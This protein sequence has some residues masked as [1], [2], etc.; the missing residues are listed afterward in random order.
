MTTMNVLLKTNES[1]FHHQIVEFA[2]MYGLS[3]WDWV[4]LIITSFSLIIAIISVIIATKTLI[5]QKA[6][7]KNTQP[8]MNIEIQQ[9]L[10]GQKLLCILDSYIYLFALQYFLSKFN[11]KV[12][13]SSH[14]WEL[15]KL[16]LE[17]MDESLFYNDNNKFVSFHN[18]KEILK[19]FNSSFYGL[20][21]I[22]L[23]KKA[24]KKEKDLELYHIYNEIG[25]IMGSTKDTLSTCFDYSGEQIN[26]FLRDNFISVFETRYYKIHKEKFCPPETKLSLPYIEKSESSVSQNKLYRHFSDLVFQQFIDISE[27]TKENFI[28]LLSRHVDVIIMNTPCKGKIEPLQSV[29][30]EEHK[31]PNFNIERKGKIWT[32]SVENDWISEESIEDRV[33]PD[34]N[35]NM[36]GWFFYITAI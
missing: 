27:E 10:I 2:E 6:T 31:N 13:P 30:K 17:D 18:F 21:E 3:T 28:N 15:T 29:D 9:F 34:V 8:I 19:E 24:S 7:Q 4:A 35:I 20:K 1:W 11:Y 12:K 32:S 36:S 14:F 22:L 26:N 23:D 33:L 25:R 16:S 5:S